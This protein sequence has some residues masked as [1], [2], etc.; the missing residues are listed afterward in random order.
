MN[1]LHIE[2]MIEVEKQLLALVPLDT[3]RLHLPLPNQPTIPLIGTCLAPPSPAVQQQIERLLT[4]TQN[5]KAVRQTDPNSVLRAFGHTVLAIIYPPASGP[6]SGP[7]NNLLLET[8]KCTLYSEDIRLS[9][10]AE[11]VEDLQA[12]A[13]VARFFDLLA[14][15]KESIGSDF[16][17]Y[18]EALIQCNP[19][20]ST[21][22][23]LFYRAVLAKLAL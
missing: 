13:M 3:Y 15:Q 6:R 19:L 21:I 1:I 2:Q 11:E 5:L 16:G 12:K 20:L 23:T 7:T 14:S 18:A 22:L 10:W 4:H 17:Q 9:G 8:L